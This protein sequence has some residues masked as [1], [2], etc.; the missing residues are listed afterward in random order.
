[1]KYL[2]LIAKA[3]VLSVAIAVAFGLFLHEFTEMYNND[4]HLFMVIAGIISFIISFLLD[5]QV[6]D[7]EKVKSGIL[8]LL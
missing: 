8:R 7:I 4:I 5:V 6:F 2:L 3:I 1:M